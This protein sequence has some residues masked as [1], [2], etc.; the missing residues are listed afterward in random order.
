MFNIN[1]TRVFY[2]TH[3][4]TKKLNDL[5]LHSENMCTSLKLGNPSKSI[6]HW[7]RTRWDISSM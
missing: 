5:R 6:I 7:H 3:R 2:T 4:K 1:K